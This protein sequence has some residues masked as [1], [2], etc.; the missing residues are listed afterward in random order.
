MF[1]HFTQRGGRVDAECR[2]NANDMAVVILSCLLLR[3]FNFCKIDIIMFS[4]PYS[5]DGLHNLNFKLVKQV[6][7][8]GQRSRSTSRDRKQMDGL[9]QEVFCW[10]I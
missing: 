2:K 9:I 3:A 8:I 10:R 6:I 5:S 7:C 1:D 4:V